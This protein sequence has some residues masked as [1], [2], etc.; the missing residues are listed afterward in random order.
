MNTT[1][2]V[3]VLILED[4]PVDAELMVRELRRAGLKVQAERVETEEAFVAGLA[5]QPDL[6]LS[7]NALPL[8][9][10]REALQLV[11][12]SGRD[13]PFIIVSG[14]Y[15]EEIAA[16]AIRNGADGYVIKDEMGRLG[17]AAVQA[18]DKRRER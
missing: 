11:R 12:S 3:R 4:N 5:A 10:S 15:R 9:G 14:A 2:S 7:D 17:P 1:D 8:F 6:V 16:E 13:V 18:I